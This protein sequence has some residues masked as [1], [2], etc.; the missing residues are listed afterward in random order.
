MPWRKC[1]CSGSRG[2]KN[3]GRAMGAT[4]TGHPLIHTV[5]LLQ[6]CT[7]GFNRLNKLCPAGAILM[8][9]SGMLPPALEATGGSCHGN[10]GH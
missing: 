4:P 3:Y 7:G 5:S 10:R 6:G 8:Y 1:K 9:S 2:L